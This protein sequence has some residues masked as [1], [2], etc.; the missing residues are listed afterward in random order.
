MYGEATVGPALVL[1]QGKGTNLY[2]YGVLL[3]YE[4]IQ[5]VDL[6]LRAKAKTT[7]RTE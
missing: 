7:C 6:N 5:G 3:N 2:K 4:G 1:E